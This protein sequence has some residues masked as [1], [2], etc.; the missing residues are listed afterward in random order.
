[1]GTEILCIM[2]SNPITNG[3]MRINNPTLVLLVP[4]LIVGCTPPQEEGDTSL[5]ASRIRLLID[6]DANNELDDQHAIAYALLD[7]ETFDVEGITVNRTR[8]GGDIDDQALEAERILRLCAAYGEVPLFKGASGTYAEILPHLNEP[9]FDGSEA[10][11]FIIERA[12]ADDPRPLVLA[13]VG[14]LTNIALALA[15]APE[16]ADRVRIIWLGSNWPEPGEYNLVNDTTAVNPVIADDAPFEI[17]LVRYGRYSGT[18]AVQATVDEIRQLMP[19][20]GPQIDEPVEGRHG[21]SFDR[22]GDYSVELFEQVGN[23]SR[24]LFDMAAIAVIKNPDWADKREVTGYRLSGNEWV[25]DA[26]APPFWVW[27]NFNT[28]KILEDFFETVTQ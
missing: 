4:F 22:F 15:K 9:D 20:A 14:K 24:A 2:A 19:G 17:A 1:M 8:N 27:E 28:S 13:P 23:Q 6:S 25:R 10:V 3:I 26:D 16:I 21:G 12:L 18:A 11:D 7:E 5:R